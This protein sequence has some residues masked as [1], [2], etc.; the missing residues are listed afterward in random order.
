MLYRNH[1]SSGRCWVNKE[2]K[3]VSMDTNP[4]S[5]IILTTLFL[6]F[7]FHLSEYTVFLCIFGSAA[8]CV[9][10]LTVPKQMNALFCPAETGSSC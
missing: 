7:F 10:K 5:F 3:G 6:S 1:Q 4:P 2:K 8:H 9:L